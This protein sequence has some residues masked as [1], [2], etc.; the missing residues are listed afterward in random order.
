MAGRA[1]VKEAF[2]AVCAARRTVDDMRLRGTHKNTKRALQK[3][4][5]CML[6]EVT[7]ETCNVIER[8]VEDDD[9]SKM[10]H[11]LPWGKAMM[12]ETS[13]ITT[14]A[15]EHFFRIGGGPWA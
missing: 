11:G 2:S 14:A 12:T 8:A 13:V 7:R 3:N 6:G 5:R 9:S 10:F 1:R 15:R 4:E